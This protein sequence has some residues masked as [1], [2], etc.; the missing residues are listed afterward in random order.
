[1][2]WQ[3]SS[4]EI[5]TAADLNAVTLPWNAL[6][7]MKRSSTLSI[8]NNA[9]TAVTWNSTDL[10]PLNWN[11]TGVNPTRITPTISGWYRT[12]YVTD[13]QSDTDYTR[14]LAAVQKNGAATTPNFTLEHRP[15]AVTH[16]PRL[17]GSFPLLQMN[18]T[19]DYVELVVLQVNTSA[20][21]NTVDPQFLV[22]LVYPA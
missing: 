15:A 13:W 21:A 20:G 8:S 6:C 7:Q 18:G 14:I 10:D 3:W 22:E 16:T 4:G 11:D 17:A 9:A 1:M 2:T 12:S 5:L 19:T